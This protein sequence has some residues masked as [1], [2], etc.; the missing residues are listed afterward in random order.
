MR[1]M[2]KLE[3]GGVLDRHDALAGG[4]LAR[5]RVEQRGLARPRATCNRQILAQ[6]HRTRQQ[7][8]IPKR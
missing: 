8:R 6:R 7:L 4:Y 1:V 3:L 5:Q 2:R